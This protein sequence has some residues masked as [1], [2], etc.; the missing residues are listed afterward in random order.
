MSEEPKLIPFGT[1]PD[2]L[3]KTIETDGTPGVFNI[4]ISSSTITVPERSEWQCE[5]FGMGPH[6]MIWHPTKGQ[7]PNWFWR[8]MQYLAFG[9]KWVRVSKVP[10]PFDPKSIE[11]N[12]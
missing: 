5:M 7:E 6:G 12:S 1:C 8:W 11:F 9:N 4:P 3:G 2:W 10:K